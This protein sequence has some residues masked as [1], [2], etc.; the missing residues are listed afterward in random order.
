[1]DRVEFIN[2]LNQIEK[3]K[4]IDKQQNKLWCKN[5]EKQKEK[6]CIINILQKK[7]IL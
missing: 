7:R 3:E 1:M 2:A 4:G 6:Y 5:L